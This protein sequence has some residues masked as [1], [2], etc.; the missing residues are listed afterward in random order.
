MVPDILEPL[1][2]VRAKCVQVMPDL[3]A[4]LALL[5]AEL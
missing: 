3:H 4:A 5:Q 2:E 1:P